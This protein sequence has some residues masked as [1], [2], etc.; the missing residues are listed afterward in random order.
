VDGRVAK[1]GDGADPE[2]QR[3]AVD[4][5]PLVLARHEYWIAHKPRGVLTTTRDPEG[6]RTVLA[7]LP[8]GLPRLFP[9][10]RLDQDTEG[11]VLLTNDGDVTQA[12]LHPSLGSERAYVVTVKGA[13]APDT[14]RRL[15]AGGI[16]LEDG[17]TAPAHVGPP[18]YDRA[19]DRTRFD[20]VLREGRKRQI[21]R[22]MLALGHPVVR[23]VRVR[24]G[25]IELGALASGRA[26]R[27]RADEVA[28]LRAHALRLHARAARRQTTRSQAAQAGAGRTKAR[29][30][31][32]KRGRNR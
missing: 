31:P 14:L 3:V 11:L 2:R 5:K 18:R 20:L 25:P 16:V 6:R 24:M 23:L 19:G 30:E 22:V 7:L 9:V 29:K 8:E 13:V 21:R 12:L 10:G 15:A 1:L 26:R 32:S 28:A 27:L 4:G 17:P